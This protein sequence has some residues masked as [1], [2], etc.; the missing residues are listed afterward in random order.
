[1]LDTIHL[2]SNLPSG[3]SFNDSYKDSTWDCSLISIS[4]VVSRY[5]LVIPAFDNS[6]LSKRNLA[7]TRK[8]GSLTNVDIS[9][10]RS[11]TNLTTH[12]CTRP[13]LKCQLLYSFHNKGEIL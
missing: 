2:L 3:F 12:D 11:A 4:H 1:M 6:F 10:S 7:S 8:N 9:P 13:A 5:L